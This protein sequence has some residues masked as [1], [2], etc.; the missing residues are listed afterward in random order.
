MEKHNTGK[1][2]T[3]VIFSPTDP[4]QA[5]AL[6]KLLKIFELH[7]VN[8]S[9]IESRSSVRVDGYEF[10]VELENSENPTLHDALEELRE[11]CS[12]FQVIARD[13][14][15]DITEEDV[16][17]WFPLRIR[18]L[19]RFANQILSYGAELDADHPG[20]N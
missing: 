11:F 13:F 3:C 9:H 17:P 4:N 18:D 2:K 14:N 8:L 7:K 19:D 5:G 20:E 1:S 12:Y 15:D 10:M 6:A 16:V